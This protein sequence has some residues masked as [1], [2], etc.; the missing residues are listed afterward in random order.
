MCIRDR[1]N[2]GILFSLFFIQ[3]VVGG[4]QLGETDYIVP[5]NTDIDVYKRQLSGMR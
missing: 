3:F 1:D 5:W 4:K 2:T